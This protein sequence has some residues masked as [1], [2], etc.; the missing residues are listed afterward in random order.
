MG[1]HGQQ[2]V[3]GLS[4][5]QV[6]L[7]TRGGAEGRLILEITALCHLGVAGFIL[8]CLRVWDGRGE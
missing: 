4:A 2:P 7:L 1:N 3:S 6:S 8:T 5:S